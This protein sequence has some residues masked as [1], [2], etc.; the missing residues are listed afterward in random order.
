MPEITQTMRYVKDFLHPHAFGPIEQTFVGFARIRYGVGI[1]ESVVMLD[2]SQPFGE[3]KMGKL[4]T[5]TKLTETLTLS[6]CSDGFWLYDETRGMN[7]G[8]RAKTPQDAFVKCI[9]YYQKR[10]AEVENEHRE[11]AIKVDAF[12]SQFVEDDDD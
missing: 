3:P 4:I 12:V 1:V 9:S 6:E 2:P 8:M 11:L 5:S 7:L 10:L